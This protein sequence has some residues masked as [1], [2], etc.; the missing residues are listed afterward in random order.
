MPQTPGGTAISVRH[1]LCRGREWLDLNGIAKVGQADDGPW[2]QSGVLKEPRVQLICGLIRTKPMNDL[3][4][5]GA[6]QA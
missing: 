1:A 6:P 4:A 5:D 3:G 2:R